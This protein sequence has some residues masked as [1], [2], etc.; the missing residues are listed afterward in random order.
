MIFFYKSIS[1]DIFYNPNFKKYFCL[2]EKLMI[3]RIIIILF[4]LFIIMVGILMLFNPQKARSILRKAGSTNLINYGEITLRIVPA[5]SMVLYSEDS[6][7]PNVLKYFGGFMIL[8]SL[9]LYCIPK[10]YH[11][12]YAVKSAEIL[13]PKIVRGLSIVSFLF[14][15]AVIYSVS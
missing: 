5:L 9:V 11:H 12:A 2:K 15:A 1:H 8:T 4:G 13:K 14:G 7:Y 6:L 10:E 3:Y